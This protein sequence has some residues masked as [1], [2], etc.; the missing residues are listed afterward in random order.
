M[1][2]PAKPGW[3]EARGSQEILETPSTI[4]LFRGP[5][6]PFVFLRLCLYV[7]L[8][9]GL[10][11]ALQWISRFAIPGALY[12]SLPNRLMLGESIDLVSALSAA[13]VMSRLEGRRFGE[14]GLPVRAAFVTLFWTGGFLQLL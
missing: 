4:S 2:D 5:S 12:S 8:V 11:F 9:E 6:L 1:S 10:S 7:A 14:Y 3:E 13:W